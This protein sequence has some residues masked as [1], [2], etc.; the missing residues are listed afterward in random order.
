MECRPACGVCCIYPSISS[1]ILRIS[2]SKP[3]GVRCVQL[4]NDSNCKMFNSPDL[5]L[6]V[7]V[8]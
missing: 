5:P 2:N 3:A 1:A 6:F 4:N 8:L 7:L